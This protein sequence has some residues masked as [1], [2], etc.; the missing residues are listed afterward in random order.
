MH[1]MCVWGNTWKQCGSPCSAPSALHTQLC[2]HAG[3]H[4]PTANGRPPTH[5]PSPAIPQRARLQVWNVHWGHYKVSPKL[6]Q[7][8]PQWFCFQKEKEDSLD[9]GLYYGFPPE[10]S[11]PVIKVGADEHALARCVTHWSRC[12]T[13]ASGAWLH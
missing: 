4:A 13:V 1:S 11:D 5:P 2:V 9:G 6:A 8:F 10:T 12:G 7:S 3:A